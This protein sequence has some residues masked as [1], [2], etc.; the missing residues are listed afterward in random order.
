MH[1]HYNQDGLGPAQRICYAILSLWDMNRQVGATVVVPKSHKPETVAAINAFREQHP[2]DVTGMDEQHAAHARMQDTRA[3]TACGLEP[4][5]LRVPAGDLVLFDTA[6]FHGAT[7]AEEPG[8][9]HLLRAIFIQSMAPTAWLGQG[10]GDDQP[11]FG[12]D[13]RSDVIRARIIAYETGVVTGGSVYCSAA[14]APRL[15]RALLE[16]DEKDPQARVRSLADAS[17]TVQRLVMGEAIVDH[18]RM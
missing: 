3:F 7:A 4:V 2:T 1:T 9:N 10:F 15:A 14:M 11:A 12:T 8:G 5:L 17:A 16:R 18:A 13:H 6:T